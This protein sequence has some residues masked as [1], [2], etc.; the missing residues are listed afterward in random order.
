MTQSSENKVYTASDLERYH[1]GS[2]SATEMHALEKAAMEDPFLADALEGYTYS[3]TPKDDLVK[4]RK[5]IDEK[6]NPKKTLLFFRHTGWMKAAAVLILVAGGSLLIYNLF[7]HDKNKV[8]LQPTK[9]QNT[10]LKIS[11]DTVANENLEAGRDTIQP[12]KTEIVLNQSDNK[13]INEG[14]LDIT[15]S[16][17]LTKTK[18]NAVAMDAGQIKDAETSVTDDYR[19]PSIVAKAKRNDGNNVEERSIFN[20][21]KRNNQV[22]AMNRAMPD[23]DALNTDF[24]NSR[25]NAS[26]SY[27]TKEYENGSIERFAQSNHRARNT[28]NDTTQVDIVLRQEKLPPSQEIV[29]SKGVVKSNY[30]KPTVIID[31]LEPTGGYYK[32]DNYIASNINMPDE[33][34]NKPT[35][36]EV[37]LS[38]DVDKNGKPVNITILKSLCKSCDQEAIR[39]LEEGPKWKKEKDR[40]G[41]VT[42]RF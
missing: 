7:D 26:N 32:F 37:Q 10:V 21:D 3:K 23:P 35:A 41:K 1:S 36:G 24:L 2:M 15:V 14:K 31:T 20:P 27:I 28:Y 9:T 17:E 18:S 33:Y 38:F 8:A 40:K 12:G 30:K 22:N 19:Q 25:R 6:I 5:Q 16:S 34:I 42:I 4:I 13:F 39:L 11:D 29:L